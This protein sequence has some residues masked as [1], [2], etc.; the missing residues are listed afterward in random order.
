M[1]Y[2]A[3]QK[4]ID[5][6]IIG[7]YLQTI[8]IIN[9]LY[10]YEPPIRGSFM[11]GV[12]LEFD[13]PVI[14]NLFKKTKHTDFIDE[15]GLG[16][17]LLVNEKVRQVFEQ[18]Y[19]PPHK[20]HPIRVVQGKKEIEGYYWLHYFD[21]V[22]KYLDYSKSTIEVYNDDNPSIS[23]IIKISSESQIMSIDKPLKF[24]MKLRLKECYLTS[25]FPKYDIFSIGIKTGS[26]IMSER[27]VNYLQEH[28]ITGLDFFELDKLKFKL[29]FSE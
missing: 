18:F 26:S 29:S 23:E 6:K 19:L 1:K 10:L 3:F 17:G 16:F 5:E 8:N 27:L 13:P 20:Y 24:P 22:Y 2:L 11:K 7:H 9:P 4:S 25:D 15:G 21:D 28:K 12:F 14:V